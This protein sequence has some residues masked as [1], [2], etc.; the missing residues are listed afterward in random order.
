M[1]GIIPPHHSLRLAIPSS[2]SSPCLRSQALARAQ[3]PQS[4]AA[5][6]SSPLS[7]TRGPTPSELQMHLYESFLQRKTADVALRIRG[8]WRAIYKLH[9]VVLIQA[10]SLLPYCLTHVARVP[11]GSDAL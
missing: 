8:S 1:S 9:R 11:I 2:A 6:T 5:T 10:V 4:M 3:T 7:P